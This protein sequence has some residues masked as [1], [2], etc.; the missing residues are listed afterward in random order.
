MNSN[1]SNMLQA[2]DVGKKSS[3]S[4]TIQT[5]QNPVTNNIQKFFNSYMYSRAP[6]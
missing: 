4:I 2:G 6:S 5:T 1:N 3:A